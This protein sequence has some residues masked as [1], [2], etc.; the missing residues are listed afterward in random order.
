MLQKKTNSRMPG[1]KRHVPGVAMADDGLT[2]RIDKL[3]DTLSRQ[4]QPAGLL[5]LK[6]RAD[7][8]K[9]NQQDTKDD[10][11]QRERI[12]NRRSRLRGM[13]AQVEQQRINRPSKQPVQETVQRIE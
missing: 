4:L 1:S 9:Q 12:G 7:Q 2:L 8:K 6:A 3:V 5:N 13:D 11:L 10:E